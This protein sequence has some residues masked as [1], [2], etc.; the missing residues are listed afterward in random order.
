MIFGG[1]GGG[2]PKIKDNGQNSSQYLTISAGLLV[3]GGK[4]GHA[5]LGSAAGRDGGQSPLRLLIHRQNIPIRSLTYS[6]DQ[7]H[8]HVMVTVMAMHRK[9]RLATFPSPAGMSLVY[10]FLQSGTV[11]DWHGHFPVMILSQFLTVSS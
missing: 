2:P 3:I 6:V 8:G 4:L 9:K 7:C 5:E 1:G 11:W 10:L